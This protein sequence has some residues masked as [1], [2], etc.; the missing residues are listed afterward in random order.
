M[1]IDDHIII[2]EGLKALLELEEDMDIVYEGGSGM[3]CL[4]ALDQCFPDVIL[5][6]LKMPGI[7]GIEVSRVVK[8]RKPQI[9]VILLTN[10]DDEPY[11]LGAI[12][13]DAD[14]YVLK[15]IK[16]GD[17][18]KIIRLVLEGHAYLD[19]SITGKIL[20]NFKK[21]KLSEEASSRTNFSYRELQ[22]LE[23][24]T[25]GKSNQEIAD[26]LCLSVDTIKSHLKSIY[27][28]LGVCNRLQAIKLAI[29]EGFIHLGY[30]P[31]KPDSDSTGKRIT[32]PRQSGHI[33]P[34]NDA[35]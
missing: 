23:R 10:Y 3:E 4:K 1:I 17:L 9:K 16:K 22:V 28:K 15:N 8:Q 32:I 19:P 5:L 34:K 35:E 20:N 25:E 7:S 31:A 21:S 30:S 29:T 27:K 6:D 11:V 33:I 2:R 13:A 12:K 26:N 18:I 24:L 14:G